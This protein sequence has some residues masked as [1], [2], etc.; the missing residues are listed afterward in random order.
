MIER[1]DYRAFPALRCC[2]RARKITLSSSELIYWP[3]QRGA[4]VLVFAP[5]NSKHRDKSSGFREEA[6][7]DLVAVCQQERMVRPSMVSQ[8]F[9]AERSLG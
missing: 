1:N 5:S 2:R 7:A 4:V 8:E 3:A 6:F 9:S